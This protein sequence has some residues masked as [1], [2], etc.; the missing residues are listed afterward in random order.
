MPDPCFPCPPDRCQTMFA[1]VS[2]F[3]L[4]SVFTLRIKANPLGNV[5]LEGSKA[6]SRIKP[7]NRLSQASSAL[8]DAVEFQRLP[9]GFGDRFQPC[10]YGAARQLRQE[11]VRRGTDEKLVLAAAGANRDDADMV[12]F[13]HRPRLVGRARESVEHEKVAGGVAMIGAGQRP[14]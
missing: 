6:L 1:S 9:T 12:A 4:T 7:A 13:D 14:V 3:F 5:S 2:L 11:T 8:F 10:R